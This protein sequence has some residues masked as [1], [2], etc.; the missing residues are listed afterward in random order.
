MTTSAGPGMARI[1]SARPAA[2][3][4]ILLDDGFRGAA[5]GL[6]D[7]I[8]AMPGPAEVVTV[9]ERLVLDRR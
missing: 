3:R 4:R 7:T 6:A 9:L 5:A 1:V 8:R 2:A